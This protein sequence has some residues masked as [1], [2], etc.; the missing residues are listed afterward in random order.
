MKRQEISE[1][2]K[3]KLEDIFLSIEEWEKS[4]NALKSKADLCL[5]YRGNLKTK[6]Q[7]L[8]CLKDSENISQDAEKLYAYA[9]MREDEDI[10][11]SKYKILGDRIE[12]LFVSIMAKNSFIV[13]SLSTLPV[14]FLKE[15]QGSPEFADYNYF[16]K[17][18]I[19][20]KKHILSENEEKLLAE[21]GEIYGSF[22][23][24]FSMIDNA[25][26]L[27][28]EINDENG[29]KVQLSHAKYGYYMQSKDRN[30]RKRVF[31]EYYKAY[32]NQIH[33]IAQVY[34]SSVKKDW[35]LSKAHKFNSCM[36][37]A[38]KDEDVSLAVYE[39][40]LEAVGKGLKPLHSYVAFRKRV[41][42]YKQLHMYDMHVPIAEN[43]QLQ[44]PYEKACGL[45]LEGLKPLGE[46]YGELLKKAFADRWIDVY[47][48]DGKK[49][50]AYS[51]G[52]HGVHPYVLLNYEKTAHE[53][54]TIAHELGHSLHS[55][56]SSKNQPYSKSDY[57]IFVAEVASTVNEVLLLKHIVK[58][59]EDVN[60]KKYLLSYYLDMF[61]TTLFRQT[62]FSEFE[63]KVHLMAENNEPLT[64][65][66]MSEIYLE[67]N[68]KYY[69]KSVVSDDE[70]K[71]E[72]AR[73]PHFYRNFYVYKYATGITCAISIAK[74]VLSGGQ[75]EVD[76]YIK[77]LS[78]GGS[79]SP[80]E[81][82]KIAGVDLT[83][84]KPY[85]DAMTEF[86]DTL[87]ELKKLY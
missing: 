54:F 11:D 13:P 60:L 83:T 36:E 34:G 52:V 65:E 44:L 55:Y 17:K 29:K 78:S 43:A 3:W 14:K 42:K 87:N 38:L 20:D 59:T 5:K 24:I 62:M 50:G 77:F 76:A 61:R 69:G 8:N 66:N 27:L 25:D 79:D 16:F 47:E 26:L 21:G 57:T 40:L 64:N 1:E 12:N 7:I 39:K 28:P 67:L 49:S 32:I 23:D 31:K 86:E 6:E 73:I 80:V 75:R 22:S 68:K 48:N 15:L 30:L 82:L 45:V 37:R 35:Y 19:E 63:N 53:I 33:T 41:L 84:K 58:V 85:K 10:R 2:N 18:L 81:L 4:F 9:K 71:Y 51:L 70:I 72:W 56:Y 46:E 74:S